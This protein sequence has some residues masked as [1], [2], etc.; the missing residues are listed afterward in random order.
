M[1]Q[2]FEIIGGGFVI[3][4]IIIVGGLSIA[5]SNRVFEISKHTDDITWK[6]EEVQEMLQEMQKCLEENNSKIK[7]V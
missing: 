7:D 1:S 4:S 2:F 3:S 5:T 6:L